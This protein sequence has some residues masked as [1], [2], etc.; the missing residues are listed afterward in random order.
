METI[1]AK[2]LI[3]GFKALENRKKYIDSKITVAHGRFFVG[4]SLIAH[5]ENGYIIRD[6]KDTPAKYEPVFEY[7]CL[8]DMLQKLLV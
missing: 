7:F 5:I 6:K 4:T 8:N 1:N 3:L 2:R